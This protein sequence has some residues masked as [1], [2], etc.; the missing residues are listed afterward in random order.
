MTDQHVPVL[1]VGGSLVG[2][3]ASLCSPG[4]A[5]APARRA[6]PRHG[7]PSAGG[8]LPPAH[9]GDLPQRRRADGVEA[10]AAQ[11]FVQNGAIVAVET[12]RGR[13]WPTSTGTSTRA[14]RP[15]PDRPPV[16]HPGRAR[17]GAARSA[18]ERGA[19]IPSRPTGLA[20][21]RTTTA[22]PRSSAPRD[23]GERGT[24]AREYLVAADGAHSRIRE[25]LGIEM[26]GHGAS[27]TASPSTSAPTCATMIG[28]RN[29]SVIYVNHPELLGFFRFSIDRRLRLPRRL[30][31]RA[32]PSSPTPRCRRPT[33]PR[34][35][36]SSW[37]AWP[38]ARR[39]A[40]RDR[41]RAALDA[42]ADSAAPL[43]RR[44]GLPGRRRRP[45]DAADRR[46]RRQHRRRRTPT[47][48]PG[49]WPLVLDGAAGPGLLDTY[50]AERRP[51]GE[52]TVEQAYTRYVLR[53][54]PSLPGTTRRRRSTR[55]RSSWAGYRSAAVR[56]RR[57]A[58]TARSGGPSHPTGGPSGNTRAARIPSSGTAAP[59]STLEI[60][61]AP[62]SP[63][64][65]DRAARPGCDAAARLAR[66]PGPLV[67]QRVAPDGALVDPGDA[68]P[69]GLRYRRGRCG[70]R[71]AGRDRGLAGRDRRV[72]DCAAEVAAARCSRSCSAREA[73]VPASQ[74][75][76]PGPE[77]A[78]HATHDDRRPRTPGCRR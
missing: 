38:S 74:A 30:R 60:S 35:A 76:G 51:V 39:H 53:V 8:V 36:A 62:A 73:R 33:S 34:S 57:A 50:D 56:A 69:G 22:S 70:P 77:P 23:G 49:S 9:D 12:L 46:L 71:P 63:C 7:D 43:P 3:S 37:S 68:L 52:F 25:Q 18:A 15:Q 16:H 2:L 17:A 44:P 61:P 64:S 58:T 55:R 78:D 59:I 72:L 21:R 66:P 11:E 26:D 54:D 14:S 45:R 41:E 27:P 4:M 42:P 31:D 5:S 47:T 20:S 67:A 48:S 40:G 28:D 1:I 13:S 10:A 6:P 65:P 24:C 32:T 75:S 19:G 29:L